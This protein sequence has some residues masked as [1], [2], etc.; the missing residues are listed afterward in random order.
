M[1]N[2]SPILFSF[3][4]Q[5]GLA[6]WSFAQSGAVPVPEFSHQSGFY[7]EAFTLEL[8]AS[9]EGDVIL[10]T[11]DGSEPHPENIEGKTY[12]YKNQYPQQPGLPFG[13]TLVAEYFTLIYTS[14]LLIED[15]SSEPDIFSQKSSTNEFIPLHIPE[16]PSFKGTVVRA[17][18]WR[19][20]SELSEIR[21]ETFIVTASGRARYALPVISL[22]FN[23]DRFYDYEDGFGN[24]GITFDETRLMFPDVQTLPNWRNNFWRRGAEWE[25]R[26]HFAFFPEGESAPALLHDCGMRL[27]GSSSRR[28]P[29]KSLRLY[30]RS[31]YG[32]S[33]FEYPFFENL[34]DDSFNR[35]IAHNAGG[36][37][38]RANLR[39]AAGQRIM[40]ELGWQIQEA[41][42]VVVLVNG[43]FYGVNHIR[44]RYDKHYFERRRGI[45]EEYL[46]LY[47]DGS[48]QE[49][50]SAFLVQT[51]NLIAGDNALA[52]DE[53]FAAFSE[54]VNT[55]SMTD[56]FAGNFFINNID[57]LSNNVLMFRS[58]E[59]G[60][61]P[62]HRWEFAVI[63]LDQG[64]LNLGSAEDIDN[65]LLDEVIN[66]TVQGDS[67]VFNKTGAPAEFFRAAVKNESYRHAF[68]SRF[69]D[70]L[71]TH[72]LPARCNAIVEDYALEIQPHMAEHFLRWRNSSSLSAWGNEIQKITSFNLERPAYQRQHLVDVFD[73]EGPFELTL[74]V[75]D[76]E[77]GY[78]RV[79]TVDINPMTPGVDEA[80]YPWQG[81]Y[82][83]GVPAE[84]T[85]VAY[86]GYIFTGW[87][88]DYEATDD[89]FVFNTESDEVYMK[90]LFA[91]DPDPWPVLLHYWHFNDL[92]ENLL[93]IRADSS[94]TGNAATISYPG[95]GD[96]IMDDVNDGTEV[97][98][99]AGQSTGKALRVRNPSAQRELIVHAP[100]SGYRDLRVSYASVRTNNG[101]D[102]R[103]VF[104]RTH[105]DNPWVL[106]ETQTVYPAWFLYE[107]DFSDLPET[108]DNPHFALRFIFTGETAPGPDGNNRFDNLTF[109]AVPIE[110]WEEP[111]F[112]LQD[113]DYTLDSWN[114]DRFPGESPPYMRFFWSEDPSGEDYDPFA[115]G[116]HPYDCG[117]DLNT[118]PRINGRGD[119]GFSFISTGNPQF[120]FCAGDSSQVHRYVG[121]AQIGIHTQ[122]IQYGQVSWTAR[123]I[124]EGAR[125]FAVRLQYRTAS[126][127]DYQDFDA[128]VTFSS[129]G[130][131]EGDSVRY[132]LQ[133][134][135]ELIG[136]PELDL[137]W[138]YLQEAGDSGNRPEIAVDDIEICACPPLRTSSR[139]RP[140]FKVFPNPAENEIR[141]AVTGFTLP[142]HISVTDLFGK[143]VLQ[144]SLRNG[145]NHDFLL[146]IGSLS[147]G[148]YLIRAED[149]NRTATVKVVKY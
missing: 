138:V 8:S 39:D 85:A 81:T 127:Q 23:E 149:G 18:V 124:S 42:P 78:I 66:G 50:D 129:Q 118:R 20:E 59:D 108:D 114:P 112:A 67:V 51:L 87:E 64:W 93:S 89:H 137:R 24:A 125:T 7:T 12:T 37:Q 49:G 44:E 56:I 98:L 97:N 140:L 43:E 3:V 134:P 16:T 72:L 132:I 48:V 46:D 26:A 102:T 14:P 40:G 61:L 54:K 95:V 113:G 73:L 71:N 62:D 99:P 15:R 123:L 139:D 121:S 68:I 82:F 22:A 53:A 111:R 74:D 41:Q 86:P 45:P 38:P 58:K 106:I 110:N 91:P 25:A 69:A 1:K 21:S 107:H 147:P 117:Y 31:E 131:A 100:T 104:Y 80:P 32:A 96:G 29:R 105:P 101:S 94:R 92:T 2:Y 77:H 79:N 57:W 27:H 83:K 36:D 136:I 115:P 88:G 148:V 11:L 19:N 90:A 17:R 6:G 130:K 141:G 145:D 13:D 143:T 128:P 76:Q 33:R 126:G 119:L 34:A 84:I 65:N 30:A 10:Y 103:Q 133:L 144:K 109:E 28:W 135:Q 35:I 4:L 9:E 116:M 70:L 120:D 47:K 5:L 52:D 75:S 60:P 146:H 122:G 55:A 63:D 142:V